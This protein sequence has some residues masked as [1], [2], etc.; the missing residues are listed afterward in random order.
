MQVPISWMVRTC[1]GVISLIEGI[2][3]DQSRIFDFCIG[4]KA[5]GEVH[6][7]PGRLARP[8]LRNHWRRRWLWNCAAS[9]HHRERP[10]CDLW[11]KRSAASKSHEWRYHGLTVGR[12][13]GPQG[14]L[15]HVRRRWAMGKLESLHGWIAWSLDARHSLWTWAWR[16]H[17]SRHCTWHHLLL[18][19]GHSWRRHL[20]LWCHA[21]M[22]CR[23][24]MSALCSRLCSFRCLG[25]GLSSISSLPGSPH[26]CPQLL[27]GV[28]SSR[29]LRLMQCLLRGACI[30]PCQTLCF[31]HSTAHGAQVFL[32][33]C[34]STRWQAHIVQHSG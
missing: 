19:H 2:L 24:G 9:V 22:V 21:D 7:R 11:G 14:Q 10:L 30:R 33:R 12:H 31:L 8:R 6:R 3:S 1:R 4:S 25:R 28:S 34:L 20:R 23:R 26:C 5:S 16:R 18:R 15:L 17:H 27:Q 32:T 13:L 29:R